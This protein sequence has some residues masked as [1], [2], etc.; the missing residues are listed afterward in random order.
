MDHVPS[1]AA[2]SSTRY[3]H[4][5]LHR[6]NIAHRD[7]SAGSVLFDSQGQ[8]KLANFCVRRQVADLLIAAASRGRAEEGREGED[9]VGDVASRTGHD[10]ASG[11]GT[12]ANGLVCVMQPVICVAPCRS[13][14]TMAR[15]HT[16][17]AQSHLTSHIYSTMSR[18]A[19]PPH[20]IS[21]F[22]R[23]HVPRPPSHITTSSRPHRITPPPHRFPPFDHA[24]PAHA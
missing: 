20:H 2:S 3:Q 13:C 21:H 24:T 19:L 1:S 8:A 16:T 17:S 5:D 10:H 4:A 11:L 18:F 7:I 9:V 12:S 14:G 6:Q 23:S 15:V 22:A